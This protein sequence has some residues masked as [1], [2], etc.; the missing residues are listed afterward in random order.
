ME[1]FSDKQM[2]RH[3][4]S[5][6]LGYEEKGNKEQFNYPE[7]YIVTSKW[8][9]MQIMFNVRSQLEGNMKGKKI[10]RT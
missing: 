3:Y 4:L 7:N 8:F 9:L 10:Q 5:G 1:S 6:R 2:C